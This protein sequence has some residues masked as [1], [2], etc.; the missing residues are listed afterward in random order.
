[1]LLY[2]RPTKL[3]TLPHLRPIVYF[4]RCTTILKI[5]ENTPILFCEF[6]IFTHCRCTK[7][8]SIFSVPFPRSLHIQNCR[9]CVFNINLLFAFRSLKPHFSLNFGKIIIHSLSFYTK[10]TNFKQQAFVH[11]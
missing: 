6:P 7:T 2:L 5:V 4:L 10:I 9:W 8:A 11:Q 3:L 1:M